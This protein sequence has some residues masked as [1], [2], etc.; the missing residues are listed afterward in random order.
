MAIVPY[1]PFRHIEN[2]RRNFE[3]FFDNFP[4]YFDK[5]YFAHRVDVYQTEN[6]VV[7]SF[8]IPGIEKKEDINIDLTDNTLSVSGSINKSYEVKEEE[9]HHQ[10][11]FAG[12]FHRT[13]TL[14]A[15]VQEE[16]V[17]A[18]YRNGILEVRMPKAKVQTRKKIDVQFH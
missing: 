3:N 1:D 8:E 7:A 11:R 9:L 4:T 6:E 17:K 12:Q 15:Q 14:P 16:G 18:S 5:N 10:E 2:W 13:I